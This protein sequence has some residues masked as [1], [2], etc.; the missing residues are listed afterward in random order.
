[1][2]FWACEPP[3]A[4]VKSLLKNNPPP[5]KKYLFSLFLLQFRCLSIYKKEGQSSTLNLS[6]F[7]VKRLLIK[8]NFSKDM[9][10]LSNI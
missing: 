9:E 1:M 2:S 8:G 4:L 7:N 3:P 5:K 6:F 10:V